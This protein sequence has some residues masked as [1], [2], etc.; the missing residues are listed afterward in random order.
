LRLAPLIMIEVAA[1]LLIIGETYVFFELVV[2]IG[3][4]PHNIGEY[5]GYALL[6]FVL[7]VGLGVLWFLVMLGMT[8]FYVRT[9]LRT[10]IPRPSS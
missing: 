10:L 8:R 9:K 4:F 7:T 1:F 6:K 3:Q 5:T 2:P